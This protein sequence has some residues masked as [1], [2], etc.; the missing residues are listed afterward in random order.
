MPIIIRILLPLIVIPIVGISPRPHQ[1]DEAAIKARRAENFQSYL[2]ASQSLLQVV[3]HFPRRLDLKELAGQYAILGGDLKAGTNLLIELARQRDLTPTSHIA[4]GDAASQQSQPHAAIEAWSTAL[5]AGGDP[6][7]LYPRLAEAHRKLG[8]HEAVIQNLQKLSELQP[9]NAQVIYQIGLLHAA[10]DPE[11][12]IN[13]LTRALEIDPGLEAAIQPLRRSLRTA[14]LSNNRAYSLLISGRELAAMQA[15]DL[16]EEA[17]RQATTIQPDY[18]EA[19]AFLAEARQHQSADDYANELTWENLETALRLDP[20]SVAV[21]SL[22]GLY[23]QRRDRYD[24]ALV[25]LHAA[26]EADPDNPTLHI[27]LGNTLT[28]L[29][30][31]TTAQKYYQ[32]AVE[33][34]PGDPLYWRALAAFS[35]NFELEVREVGLPAARQAVVLAPDDPAS[36]D[37]MG[38]VFMLL[39]DPL[40]ARRFLHRALLNDPGYAPARLHLGLLYLI[41]GDTPA[42][43]E[44]IALAHSLALPGTPTA[45]QANRLL[46]RY[47]P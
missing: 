17:F 36:L 44:Q 15:W 39:D 20:N 1:V 16:A 9:A 21:N 30:Q 5:Q 45:D 35:V 23:W 28:Q 25:Y 18:A 34:S 31:I 47:F 32:A 8:N 24:L 11:Q 10:R 27:E 22:T 38:R 4:L 14:R 26:V 41:E 13:Y 19:W 2:S 3:T 33:M 29:G 40:S 7:V 37:V 6:L 12:A 43:R 42:A 46:Q